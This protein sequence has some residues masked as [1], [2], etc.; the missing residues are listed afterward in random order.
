MSDNSDKSDIPLT[1]SLHVRR[2]IDLRVT[3]VGRQL[4]ERI[5]ELVES[6]EEIVLGT[7]SI[8]L[9]VANISRSDG[10]PLGVEKM[11]EAWFRASGLRESL[12]ET[13][14]IA[15]LNGMRDGGVGIPNGNGNGHGD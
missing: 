13:A 4:E 3:V 12:K 1:S 2:A 7:D 11:F 8:S 14:K 9:T 10:L 5:I 6:G 15:Y